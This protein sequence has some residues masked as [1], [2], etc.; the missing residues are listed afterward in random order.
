MFDVDFKKALPYLLGGA[1]VLWLFSK[2]KTLAVREI[3]K[4][5]QTSKV[6]YLTMSEVEKNAYCKSVSKDLRSEMDWF[7]L[8]IFNNSRLVALVKNNHFCI[9][10]V[11]DFYSKY[12]F[13]GSL[14]HELRIHL[15][16][17]DEAKISDIL[18]MLESNEL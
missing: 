13:F 16:R 8:P 18:Y 17:S 9:L 10:R 5:A 6:K 12:W 7:F 2:R 4:N 14:S 1:F 3:E 11:A 15:T